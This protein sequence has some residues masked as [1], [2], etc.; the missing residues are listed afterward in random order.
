M[1]FISRKNVIKAY[2]CRHEPNQ[3][4]AQV[5]EII[6]LKPRNES[7]LRKAIAENG[8][9]TCG[10]DARNFKCYGGGIFFGSCGGNH[11]DKQC[12]DDPARRNH[13]INIVGFG[14]GYFLLRNIWGEG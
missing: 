7:E 4:Y 1:L 13:A 10:V 6:D 5:S 11:G 12:S 8:V 9:V 14:P 3:A 2:S